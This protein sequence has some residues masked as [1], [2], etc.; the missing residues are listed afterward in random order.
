[1][2]HYGI[3]LH[4]NPTSGLLSGTTRIT[5]RL[6]Q[7]LSRFNLDFALPVRSVTVN[8]RTAAFKSKLGQDF[9][10]GKELVVTPARGLRKGSPMTVSVEYSAKPRQVKVHGVSWWARTPTGVTAVDEPIA[11]TEWW[12]PGND[13]PSYKATYDV[14]VTTPRADTVITNGQ[15]LSR[16]VHGTQA[17]S[18]WR[19]TAPVASYLASYSAIQRT[20]ELLRQHW[21]S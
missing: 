10:Y 20:Y 17:T 19:S 18:H 21:P 8:G 12:Y 4:Y 11:A 6:K 5:A 2:S 14:T 15:L 13:Y 16:K 1:V 9:Y 7:N 3:R